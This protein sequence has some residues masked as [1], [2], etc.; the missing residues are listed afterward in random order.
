VHLPRSRGRMFSAW[1]WRYWSSSC[2]SDICSTKPYDE[3]YAGVICWEPAENEGMTQL[4][5][6]E[7]DDAIRNCKWILLTRVTAKNIPHSMKKR[8]TVINR[9]FFNHFRCS[10]IN[11]MIFIL[12]IHAVYFV[13]N[14]R[15][16]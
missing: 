6:L 11:W 7:A 9:S 15:H 5:Q 14:T 3:T 2:S 16:T 12:H 1:C 13:S 10:L 8:I 4:F